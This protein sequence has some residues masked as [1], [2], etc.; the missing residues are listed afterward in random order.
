[1]FYYFYSMKNPTTQQQQKRNS[2][3]AGNTP[4][5]SICTATQSNHSSIS[6]SMELINSLETINDD[7]EDFINNDLFTK[8]ALINKRLSK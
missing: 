6:D 8:T 5:T 1:M 4:S 7:E 2:I 3:V